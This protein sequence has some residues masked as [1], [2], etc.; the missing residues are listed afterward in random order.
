MKY[1]TSVTLHKTTWFYTV[2]CVH[3]EGMVRS[4]CCGQSFNKC[5]SWLARRKSHHTALVDAAAPV[6]NVHRPRPLA[7]TFV[8]RNAHFSSQCYSEWAFIPEVMPPPPWLP[9]SQ[10]SPKG[11]KTCPDSRPKR[12]QNFTLLSFSAAEK[13]VTVQTK[14]DTDRKHTVN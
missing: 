13:S 4:I 14:W 7:S 11:E 10:S 12:V 5:V 9:A 6:P 8:W 1:P 2:W 3:L